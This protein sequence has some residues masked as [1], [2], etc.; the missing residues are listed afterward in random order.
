MGFSAIPYR[1]K[2]WPDKQYT[3]QIAISILIYDSVVSVMLCRHRRGGRGGAH[4]VLLG[5]VRLHA[6]RHLQQRQLGTAPD[7]KYRPQ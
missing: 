7:R 3:A 2:L 4:A 5:A 1:F 6:R